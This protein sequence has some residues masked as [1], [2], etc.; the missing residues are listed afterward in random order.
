MPPAIPLPTVKSP[1]F[2]APPP[3]DNGFARATDDKVRPVRPASRIVDNP[4][5]RPTVIVRG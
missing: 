3:G 2:D 4:S 1:E 5:E